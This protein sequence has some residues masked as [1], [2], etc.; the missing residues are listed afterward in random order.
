[1]RAIKL[2]GVWMILAFLRLVP[3]LS[4]P[5]D[6]NINYQG[7]LLTAGAPATGIYDIQFS[8][9]TALS[10]PAT[11]AEV[12]IL[13]VP[14][15]N[16]EFSVALDFGPVFDGTAY[17]LELAVK[18]NGGANSF[19]TLVPRQPITATPYAQY[20]V[21]AGPSGSG[22]TLAG[23]GPTVGG[24]VENQ[25]LGNYS[26]VGG[27][28]QNW[29]VGDYST[30][31][32]GS[33]NRVMTNASFGTIAGGSGNK[34]LQP[35]ATVSGGDRNC[36]SGGYSVV[37]GGLQNTN[38]GLGA[39]IPGG[40]RNVASA[41][42]S[43]AAGRRAKAVHSGAFV[44]G[45]STDADLASSAA[46][47]FLIRAGGGVGIGTRVPQSALDVA[48]VIN[49]SLGFSV[50]GDLPG[51][52]T[53]LSRPGYSRTRVISSSWS[54]STGDYIDIEVPGN[55][56]A[57]NQL[58]IT[59]RGNIGIGTSNPTYPLHVNGTVSA[60]FLRASA[61]AVGTPIL[62]NHA[63]VLYVENTAPA[64]AFNH[65]AVFVGDVRAT[66]FT[67]S[68]DRNAKTDI[69]TVD[70][71]EVLRKTVELDLKWWSFTNGVGVRHI[72]PMA[73][74]FRAAFGTGGDDTAIATVDAD[75]VALA[76]IQG[77]N[78]KLEEELAF[79]EREIR[80]LGNRL[81]ELE[82]QLRALAGLRAQV[83][84]DAE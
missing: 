73:Q 1:M 78:Q 60:A 68:S 12:T 76:A 7:R 47:Q 49:S 25:S 48:G 13:N 17:W 5:V 53:I 51:L 71:R 70:V 8:L 3:G 2:V 61:N 69:A 34:V 37:G 38:S 46:N 50:P 63:W 84:K 4:A 43:F 24:G 42:Y 27:G 74:D 20:A 58:R 54:G 81:E 35:Y 19:T 10:G 39:V 44:W 79:R 75:G 64:G 21:K 9:C 72:G 52:G 23:I 29:G 32:G 45:D 65:A 62:G 33:A 77:L 36:A 18:T 41:D 22:H 80:K 30:V 15:T 26:T 56:G 14:V 66:S 31:A 82:K 55:D 59:S 11:N 28:T 6:G 83:G 67:T 16:G 57:G 40:V